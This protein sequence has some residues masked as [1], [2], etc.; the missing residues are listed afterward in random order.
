MKYGEE[1]VYH[2]INTI[3]IAILI[4]LG[5]WVFFY[6]IKVEHQLLFLVWWIIWTLI[7]VIN[8]SQRLQKK[9]DID[10]NKVINLSLILYIITSICLW[11]YQLME[12]FNLGSLIISI[13]VLIVTAF[14]YRLVGN[15][16][17]LA[18]KEV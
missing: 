7:W 17:A 18:K 9:K 13:L 12:S 2:F 10:I 8:A 3:V 14:L 16:F 6:I 1:W 15:K 4:S 5:L 11:A